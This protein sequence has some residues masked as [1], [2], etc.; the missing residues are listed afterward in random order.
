MAIRLVALD[1][2]PDI[3]IDREMLIVGRHPQCDARL[4]SIRVSRRHCCMSQD[5]GEVVVRDLGSTNGIRINGQRVEKGRL[6]IGDEL[7]I[8]HIRFRLDDGQ[9]QE[10][11]VAESYAGSPEADVSPVS[12]GMK[13]SLNGRRAYHGEPAPGVP[14]AP[15]NLDSNPLAAAVR[16]L[17][18]P[19][20]ADR[21]RIQVILQM[22]EEARIEM[23]VMEME[24]DSAS[25]APNSSADVVV[26]PSSSSEHIE[27]CPPDSSL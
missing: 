12:P 24:A 18:P 17:L 19:N 25:A 27:A 26:E 1:D 7:S 10:E 15:M 9:G 23:D 21:C 4:D 8:A 13:S 6:K 5:S 14:H 22:D 3:P 2:G 16:E 11:T 20:V